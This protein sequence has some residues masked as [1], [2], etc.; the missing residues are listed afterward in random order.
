MSL[1]K[2]VRAAPQLSPSWNS[3]SSRPSLPIRKSTM[4]DIAAPKLVRAPA[5]QRALEGTPWR[6]VVIL[7]GFALAWEL[8]ARWLDHATLLPTVGA[9]LSARRSAVV[10]GGGSHST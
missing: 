9:P 10:S 2:V 4:S 3:G 1:P 6:R 8:Y 5:L 7:A